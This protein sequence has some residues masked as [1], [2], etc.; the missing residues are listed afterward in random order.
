MRILFVS[1]APPFPPTNGQ[2]L[3]NWALLRALQAEGHAVSLLSFADASWPAATQ[4]R[5][6]CQSIEF[7]PLPD[8]S[9]PGRR[10]YWNRLR[11]LASV[12]PYGAWRFRSAAMRGAVGNALAR[13]QFDT[14]ICDDVYMV[15]NLPPFPSV[16][17][18]LNKHDL[19][20]VILGRYL[21]YERNPLKRAYGRL[22][23]RK[24][25]YWELRAC[26]GVAAVLACSE[27]DCNLLRRLSPGARLAV[28]PNVIDVDFYTPFPGDDGQTVL[29]AGAMDW[30]P[31][32][33]AVEFFASAILPA[34]RQLVCD[35]RFVV[36]GR[37]PAEEVRR[38]L[39]R[40]SGVEFTGWVPDIR[41][42]LARAA[43]CVVPLRIGSGTRLK[44]LE[45][46][47]T[48][49][50]VVSTTIGAEGLQFAEGSE[51]LI[52]DAPQD[53]AVAIAALLSDPP[54]RR[55][56]GAAARRKA[57]QVYSLA[58]LRAAVRQALAE[59]QGAASVLLDASPTLSLREAP[60]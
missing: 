6:V 26:S 27:H 13:G 11:A 44:I 34:L 14:A 60:P 43:V 19:T 52:A 7:V 54:R 8:T 31:N 33:D 21:A 53:F 37:A 10:D 20:H 46:A 50:P 29:F 2:R 30:Y 9:A 51:I 35:V 45:A 15:Q 28:V 1:L 16:P 38:R 49:R 58:A 5:Q 41:P 39:E 40:V 59:L 42:L 56:L 24:L 4:L 57:E 36:A 18:L 25:R 22:E 48:A 17:V 47:A 55:V 23:C 32:R 12:L 3:R